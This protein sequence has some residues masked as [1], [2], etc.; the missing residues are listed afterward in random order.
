MTGAGAPRATF[1][2]RFHGG[3]SAFHSIARGVTDPGIGCTDWLG[4]SFFLK[5]GRSTGIGCSLPVRPL[6]LN[7]SSVG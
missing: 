1:G 5:L 6:D 2:I 4:L 3:H 7:A